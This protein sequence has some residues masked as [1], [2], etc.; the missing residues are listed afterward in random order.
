MILYSLRCDK[1][2]EFDQWFTNSGEYDELKAKGELVCPEC[3]SHNVSKALMAPAVAGK[4][5]SEPAPPPS[6]GSGMG[7]GGCGGCPFG[8]H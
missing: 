3:S 4:G 2:H 7:M 8:G 6:C 1:E 5:S